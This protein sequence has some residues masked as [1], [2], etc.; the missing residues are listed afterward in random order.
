MKR[1]KVYEKNK[2]NNHAIGIRWN[3]QLASSGKKANGFSSVNT[4]FINKSLLFIYFS[5]T[6]SDTAIDMLIKK[7]YSERKKTNV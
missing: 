3:W 4:D 6:Y 5:V 1:K 7:E 2:K